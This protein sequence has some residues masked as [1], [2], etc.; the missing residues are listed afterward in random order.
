MSSARSIAAMPSLPQCSAA[1][2]TGAGTSRRMSFGTDVGLLDDLAPLR[3]LVANEFREIRGR[4]GDELDALR[5]E[6]RLHFR[7]TQN[8]RHFHVH[9][10]DDIGRD[11]GRHEETKPWVYAVAGQRFADRRGITE[12][13]KALRRRA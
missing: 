7:T 13:R 8:T 2:A 5:R 3:V 11:L 9:A 6:L 1:C 10:I 4:V 12:I